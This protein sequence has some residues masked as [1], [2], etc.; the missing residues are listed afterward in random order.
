MHPGDFDQSPSDSLALIFHIHSE[1]GKITA[2]MKVRNRAG[3]TDEQLIVPSCGDQV[4]MLDHPLE[5]TGVINRASF[6][7]S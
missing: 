5:T 6:A 1:I 2:I 7:K 4:R 3:N